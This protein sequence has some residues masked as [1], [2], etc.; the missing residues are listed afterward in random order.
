LLILNI[1]LYDITKKQN[2]GLQILCLQMLF[3]QAFCYI[4]TS[5][6]R[7]VMIL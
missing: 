1:I 4:F 5:L 6:Q 2:N 7:A 3:Y